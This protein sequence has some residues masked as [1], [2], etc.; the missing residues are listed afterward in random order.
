MDLKLCLDTD[1]FIAVNGNEPNAPECKKI[2]NSIEVK[3][4]EANLSTV[5]KF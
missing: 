2:L 4:V 3:S 1:V 5:K